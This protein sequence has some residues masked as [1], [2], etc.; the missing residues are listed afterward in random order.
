MAN[1]I[2]CTTLDGTSVEIDFGIIVAIGEQGSGANGLGLTGGRA[3]Q[4]NK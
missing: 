2:T 3:L 4:V 1:L